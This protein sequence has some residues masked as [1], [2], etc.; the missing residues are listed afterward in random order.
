MKKLLPCLLEKLQD[1]SVV[2][3]QAGND[4]SMALTERGER[5][6]AWGQGKFGALGLSRSQNMKSP[7]EIELPAGEKIS[8]IAAGARHSAFVTDSK[9]LYMF[10]LAVHGQLGLGEDCTDRAFKPEKVDI[11]PKH[12]VE[13]VALGDTHS[14]LLTS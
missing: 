9:D 8:S 13:Q 12:Q 11:G 14:L 5:V 3:V 6:F 10:G 1:L 2:D 7:A 4:H